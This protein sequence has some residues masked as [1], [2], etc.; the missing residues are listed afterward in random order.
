[1]S[2]SERFARVT[3][4]WKYMLP[5]FL[6]F[7][8]KATINHGFY[9]FIYFHLPWLSQAEQF[10]WYLF[11]YCFA[12]II[13]RSSGTV[14][15]IRN[16]W[17]LVLLE[18]VLLVTVVTQALFSYIPSIFGMFGIVFLEGLFGGSVYVN[19]FLNLKEDTAEEFVEFSMGAVSS[20][21]STGIMLASLISIPLH[22]IICNYLYQRMQNIS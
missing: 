9:Q 8:A 14:A 20:G 7:F 15:R 19:S 3:G 1:M 12:V 4:L 10:R 11:T 6:V 21:D 22:T 2:F 13:S 16:V 18:Y 5:L 17:P